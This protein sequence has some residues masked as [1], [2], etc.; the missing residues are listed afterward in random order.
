M[1]ESI[2][3]IS[4]YIKYSKKPVTYTRQSRYDINQND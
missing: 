4:Y 2:T 3:G 1:M